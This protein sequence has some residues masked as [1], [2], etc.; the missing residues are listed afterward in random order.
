MNLLI[1]FAH[2]DFSHAL[3]DPP[4]ACYTLIHAGPF[5]PK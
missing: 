4:A 3:S 1:R 2:Y 5:H